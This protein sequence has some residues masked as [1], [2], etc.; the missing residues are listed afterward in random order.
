[1]VQLQES[2]RPLLLRK[3][4]VSPQKHKKVYWSIMAGG[5]VLLSRGESGRS[6]RPYGL[7]KCT[8]SAR[9]EVLHRESGQPLLL[10]LWSS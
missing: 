4:T 3:Y 2:P 5:R 1:M 7:L 10:G 9:A 6:R 8:G